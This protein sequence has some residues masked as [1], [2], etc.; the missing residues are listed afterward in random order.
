MADCRPVSTPMEANLKLDKLNV[1]KVDIHDYQSMMGSAMYGM[2]GTRPDLAQSVGALSRH[3]ATP[4]QH[5]QTALKRVYRYLR[6]TSEYGITYDGKLSDPDPQVYCD[7][8]WAN[9]PNDRKSISGY[10]T[11][12]C[13]GAVSWSSKKQS[14]TALSSTEAEYIAAACAAQESSWLVAFLTEIG[15]PPRKSIPLFVDNQSAIKLIMNPVTHDCTKHIDMKYH[16]VRDAQENGII[17]VKYC[18][19]GNQTADILMKP[20]S[21]EKLKCFTESM[22]LSPT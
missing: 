8:D 15:C 10:V 18:P 12:M 14:V 5:H 3:T 6:G 22:G 4:G 13:G 7:A 16:Y 9:D 1:A 2:I 19:T 17:D 11:M 21:R 20:L